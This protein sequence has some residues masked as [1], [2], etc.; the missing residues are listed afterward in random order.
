MKKAG[1]RSIAVKKRLA[2]RMVFLLVSALLGGIL[3]VFHVRDTENRRLRRDL[4]GLAD[5]LA[6]MLGPEQIHHLRDRSTGPALT[7]IARIRDQFRTVKSIHQG[8]CRLSILERQGTQVHCLLSSDDD[9]Q[10]VPASG[11]KEPDHPEEILTL[12]DINTSLVKG[13]KTG[14]DGSWNYIAFAPIRGTSDATTMVCVEMDA[15]EGLEG[16]AGEQRLAVSIVALSMAGIFLLWWQLL[17]EARSADQIRAS[18]ERF[19]GITQAAL[20]PIVVTDD[21]GRITYWNDAAERSFGYRRDEVLD[22]PLLDR[23]VPSRLHDDYRK[24]LPVV[25]GTEETAGLGRIMELAAIRKNGEEF[26]IELSAS[27]F[28]LDGQ[29]HSVGVMSDLTSRKW[30]EAELEERAAFSDAGR[31]RRCT[32]TRRVGRDDASRLHVGTFIEASGSDSDLGHGPGKSISGI[33]GHAGPMEAHD[34]SREAM[35][36]ARVASSRSRYVG[37][38]DAEPKEKGQEFTPA[39]DLTT[40]AGFPLAHGSTLEGVLAITVRQSLSPAAITT[41][42]TVADEVTLGIVRLRLINNLGAARQVAEAANRAK[43]EFLANMS[44]EIRTPMNGVIGMTELV[45]DTE[46]S[47]RQRE[48]LEIVKH[49]ADSLLTVINDILD[50]SR[51]EAGKLALDP[52]PFGLRE[53]VEET[54]RTLAERAH[55]KGLEL[56]CRIRPD[57]T[58]GVIGDANRLRQVLI[59]LVGNAI[60]F[61]EHGEVIVT[62]ES[63][64]GLDYDDQVNLVFTVSDTGVGIPPDRLNVIFEPFE[65]ADGSTTRRYGGTGLGLA[66]SSHLIGLMGGRISVAS[67]VGS[68]STFRFTVRL[69]RARELLDPLASENTAKLAGLSILV[70]DDNATNR[71]ILEEVLTSWKMTPVLVDNGP[72]ALRALRTAAARGRGFA[73]VLLD[74]MMPQMDGMELAA[75]DPGRP[76]D[77]RHGLD[78]PHVR[79][80]PARRSSAAGHGHSLDPDQA[81]STN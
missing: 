13:T 47:I 57:V 29:W 7:D 17:R 79:R 24:A 75:P 59:N 19:R 70:V 46:L 42:E 38:N 62:V 49:S 21:G 9:G 35:I 30:Y 69:E 5:S 67:Q 73:A 72:A 74:Y 12:S 64:S 26:P 33:D 52:V 22:Q 53:T 16:V 39:K 14:R 20:H 78:R 23:L 50:F 40:V 41:L 66:I 80:R 37:G 44:H 11:G 36:L 55:G 51:V 1:R 77:R 71:R 3:F 43:S 63:D 65:Q 25:Q 28:R 8:H 58:D 48:Y 27:A 4:Q 61:T 18:E 81:R 2:L 68:G 56:A 60:K 10:V 32:D 45:L 15:S 54:I 76:G 6:I 31:G 34:Q